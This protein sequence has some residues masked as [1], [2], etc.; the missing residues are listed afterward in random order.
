MAKKRLYITEKASQLGPLKQALKKLG[1]L[2]E[3]YVLQLQGHI[4]RTLEPKEYADGI[5]NWYEWYSQDKLP[6]V[7]KKWLYTLSEQGGAKF[8]KL[9]KDIKNAVKEVEEIYLAT[10]P[11]A[12]GVRLGLEVLEHIPGA[13]KKFK[14]ML[15]MN[16]TSI[17]ALIK[18]IKN[19]SIINWKELSNAGLGRAKGDWIYGHNLTVAATVAFSQ[20]IGETANVGPVKSVIMRLVV[21]R[22]E[23]FEKFK[24]IPFWQLK[25]IGNK[26]NIDF[27][28]NFKY[29]ND[30]GKYIDKIDNKSIIQEYYNEVLKNPVAKVFETK[31]Q[32]KKQKPPLPLT[33]TQAQIELGKRY[34][35]SMKKSMDIIQ[36]LYDYD[37][38]GGYI[39][40]PRTSIDKY[41][42]EEFKQFPDILNNLKN[43][44]NEVINKLDTNNL[45]KR[46]EVIQDG[47]KLFEKY[48]A[49]H[50][51]LRPTGR[52]DLEKL[53]P[54]ELK[55]YN[56]VLEF[57]LY[58]LFPDYEYDYFS[59]KAQTNHE[60][61]IVDFN[62]KQTINKG[63]KIVEEIL[64]N[65]DVEEKFILPS[66]KKGDNINIKDLKIHEGK[67][68]P[69]PR[70]TETE[71]LSV[72]EHIEKYFDDPEIKKQLK[73]KGIGTSATRTPL[74]QQL[75]KD[76]FF[77]KEKKG[78]KEYIKS[79][80]KTRKLIRT[81]PEIITSPMLRAKMEEMIFEAKLGKVTEKDIV[82]YFVIKTK[83][84]VDE[85]KKIQKQKNLQISNSKGKNMKTGL[86][87]PL[88]GG[89]IIEKDKLFV[90]ENQEWNTDTK[91]N[92]GCPFSIWKNSK[93]FDKEITKELL[94]ELLEGNEITDS[95]GNKMILDT[96]EKYF[97]KVI[98][99][100]S[101]NTGISAK[102]LDITCPLCQK[103]KLVI[104]DKL[105]KCSE[106]KWNPNTKQ[107]DGCP[108][109]IFK[110]QKLLKKKLSEKDI[111]TLIEKG[112]L[113]TKNGK[114]VLDLNNKYFAK[115]EF[116][117]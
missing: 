25:G 78:K 58:Q 37:T 108:F 9:F 91:Q 45:L 87:C 50:T 70:F 12:E 49:S 63:Y 16:D 98:F 28:I 57:F 2:E 116:N 61:V 20:L 56:I 19:P 92:E 88:C 3:S 89:E 99:N 95:S 29:K 86:K 35:F 55:V 13:M 77:I 38:K 43:K 46:K 66:I 83:E 115:V 15:N 110:E 85:I 106:A 84:L 111:K 75:Y 4:F 96:D 65:K 51:A 17:S 109:V 33:L 82:E 68:K 71:L 67:T 90:C 113:D 74:L 104:T 102:E 80:E 60:N 10:D 62:D 54:D 79:T 112:E 72:L 73:D 47:K 93:V 24:E 40:Y 26:D 94:K 53:T 5:K 7:P 31:K 59:G 21:D 114:L 23:Q 18:E 34:G 48:G 69:K 117:K 1:M 30:E 52:N 14:G 76:K 11:D 22:D 103:G 101:K 41:T 105:V 81:L 97:T 36:K 107:N 6:Y 100:K 64:N 44:Y 27:N 8:K 42:E 39:T 32:K